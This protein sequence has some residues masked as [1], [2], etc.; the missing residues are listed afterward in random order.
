VVES[1]VVRHATRDSRVD[2]VPSC[3]GKGYPCFRVPTVAPGPASGEG[4][5]L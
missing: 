3:Y 4:T 5:S 1:G 2:I